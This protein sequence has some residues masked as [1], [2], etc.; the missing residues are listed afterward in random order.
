MSKP[1][2]FSDLPRLE[3]A[4]K[5]LADV[6]HLLGLDLNLH[7]D[8]VE[9]RLRRLRLRL[10]IMAK[11]TPRHDVDRKLRDPLGGLQVALGHVHEELFG[12]GPVR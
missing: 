8:D 5:C 9:R 6:E 10:R 2:R 1:P 3:Q 4:Q 11:P 7:M 12:K